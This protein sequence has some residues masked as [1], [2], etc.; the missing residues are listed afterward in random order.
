[1]QLLSVLCLWHMS[2]LYL[3]I[4]PSSSASYSVRTLG[5]VWGSHREEILVPLSDANSTLWGPIISLGYQTASSGV[6]E[7]ELVNSLS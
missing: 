7:V 2:C 1:M 6:R 4:R 5:G 3:S